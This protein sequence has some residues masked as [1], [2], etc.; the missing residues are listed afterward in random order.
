[1]SSGVGICSGCHLG[2]ICCNS[3]LKGAGLVPF[4]VGRFGFALHPNPGKRI[5]I[6]GRKPFATT[7]GT[8][9]TLQLAPML[10]KKTVTSVMLY[11]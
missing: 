7:P 8:D 9:P 11:E 3:V 10:T 2:E 1:M 5:G 4:H 6:P